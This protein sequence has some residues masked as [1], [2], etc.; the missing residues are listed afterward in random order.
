MSHGQLPVLR[1]PRRPAE[2]HRDERRP[3]P[4]D[5]GKPSES[6]GKLNVPKVGQV[7]R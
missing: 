3:R 6:T 2:R 5:D 4:K 1:L 7:T